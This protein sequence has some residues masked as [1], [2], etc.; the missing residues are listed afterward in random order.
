MRV[1][2][3][4]TAGFC[5]GV[6]RAMNAVLETAHKT[7]KK[8]YTLGPLVHN[9]QAIEMLETKKVQVVSS[10]DEVDSGILFIRAHGITPE[11][12][13][14]L[15]KTGV[16]VC[17]MTCPHVRR[18]QRIIERH[19]RQGYATLIVGDKGHAEV[20]GLEGHAEGRSHVV[21]DEEDIRKLPDLE[22]VCV[23]AQTT[24]NAQRFETLL[25]LIQQRFPAQSSTT[26]C[27]A[28]RTTA[29]PRSAPWPAR[30]TE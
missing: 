22:K 30:W 19:A 2:L 7:D 20:I 29:R 12:R 9:R 10:V 24:Q 4:R 25:P 15:E 5:M 27:A 1:K 17:D 13:A 21:A 16:E 23:V 18:A 8:I 3:A 26:R 28:P 11:V 6:R 14:G